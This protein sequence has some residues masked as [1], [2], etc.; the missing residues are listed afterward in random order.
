VTQLSEQRLHDLAAHRSGLSDFGDPKYLDGLREVLAAVSER[1]PSA[2]RPSVRR[3]RE[4]WPTD[5]AYIARASELEEERRSNPAMRSAHNIEAE[6]PEECINVMSQS[7]ITMAF[8]TTVP[9]TRT[10]ST[11]STTSSLWRIR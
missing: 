9:L 6:L 5:P 2:Q 10:T 11:M 7:F 4:S 8:I 1:P 3:A